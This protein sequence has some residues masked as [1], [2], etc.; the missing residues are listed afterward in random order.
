[1]L[2]NFSIERI[3]RIHVKNLN[4]F[5]RH[6]SNMLIIMLISNMLISNML[7]MQVAPTK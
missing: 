5:E 6:I 1:M 4:K 7:N 2:K 3:Q